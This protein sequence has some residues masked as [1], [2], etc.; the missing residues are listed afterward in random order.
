MMMM[1]TSRQPWSRSFFKEGGGNSH[2]DHGNRRKQGV[3]FHRNISASVPVPF[4][5][6]DDQTETKTPLHIYTMKF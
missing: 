3:C 6:H 2:R 5:C 1:K 4:S